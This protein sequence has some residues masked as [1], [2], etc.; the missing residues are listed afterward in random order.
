MEVR[1]H[2]GSRGTL[3]G[4][5]TTATS[6]ARCSTPGCCSRAPA[7]RRPWSCA[8]PPAPRASPRTPP[9]A[10]SPTATRCSPPSRCTPSRRSP[11]R[12]STSWR[13]SPRA[14]D[15]LDRA[16]AAVRAVGTGYLRFA[17]AE[18][19]LFRT[20][21]T[22][23]DDLRHAA[24][25]AG[26]GPGGRTPFELLGDALDGLVA[27][28]GL[29]PEHRP[30]RRPA[31]VVGGARARHAAA[32]RSAAPP[33]RR[34]GRGAGPAAA[35]HGGARPAGLTS[36]LVGQPGEHGPQ[37][38]GPS[39][40]DSPAAVERRRP[41]PG[42]QRQPGHGVDGGEVAAARSTGSVGGRRRRPA[43]RRAP[44]G[45]RRRRW[46]GRRPLL[47][48][49][50]RRDGAGPEL[51]PEPA[52]SRRTCSSVTSAGSRTCSVEP[53]APPPGAVCG[54]RSTA[55]TP[56]AARTHRGPRLPYRP[57]MEQPARPCVV[58][59]L[60]GVLLRPEGPAAELAR[61]LGVDVE[62]VLVP[63]WRHRDAYD[64]GGPA[65]DFWGALRRDLVAGGLAVADVPD[66]ELD[67]L[68]ASRWAQ[69]ADGSA[70][71]LADLERAGTPTAVL[72][73]AP[74]SLAAH[75]PRRRRGAGASRTLVF[76][77][78][79]ALHEAGGGGLRAGRAAHRPAAAGAG[80]LRRPAAERRRGGAAGLAGP[81]VD[82]A[83]PGARGARG[84]RGAPA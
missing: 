5:T 36:G 2:Q 12:W 56:A 35:R 34:D 74:A 58:F 16:R 68:D 37:P 79:L 17:R 40:D 62:A 19:G 9:T 10:T 46:R 13:R 70:D 8:R 75:R 84:S 24:D 15:P 48:G 41:R 67:H 49:R 42:A 30:R 21:F 28:G 29:A 27:A 52:H 20:A 64:R 80:L 78:D 14:G 57:R 47:R 55:Q 66:D 45:P 59:D 23:N 51:V 33:R 11:R 6:G 65:A 26:R 63:Y 53:M 1:W 31:G 61:V 43:V 44:A 77:S 3:A 69:L 39:S 76:S 7:A 38:G 32:H 4:P 83:R 60:G 22:V 18:P 72:S 50:R 73:N 71:L 81:P 25:P 54:G 82:R